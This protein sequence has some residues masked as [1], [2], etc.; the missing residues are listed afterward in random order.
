MLLP[1]KG[2]TPPLIKLWRVESAGLRRDGFISVFITY[3]CETRSG[4]RRRLHE[5]L[6]GAVK[7]AVNGDGGAVPAGTCSRPAAA[8]HLTA[9]G[10]QVCWLGTADRGSGL[11]FRLRHR[12]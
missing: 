5:V 9:R 11:V 2:L 6:D 7:S 8:H 1:T 3:I 12:H 10:W 4:K